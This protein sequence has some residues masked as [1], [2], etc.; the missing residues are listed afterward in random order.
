M[1]SVS[2]PPRVLLHRAA[3]IACAAGLFSGA[4]REERPIDGG[5]GP[6]PVSIY[7]IQTPR[8]ADQAPRVGDD[9]YLRS[10]LVVAHDTHPEPEARREQ[11]ST[12]EFY[13]VDG[14]GYTG[15]LVVQEVGGGPFSGIS[16]FNPTIVPSGL[17]LEPGDL[18]DVWGQYLEFC[19]SGS[20]SSADSYCQAQDTNRLSQIGSATV[21][22]VGEASA[23]EP[24][25]IRGADLLDPQRAE[26]Y[27]GT[28]VRVT[29]RL[30]VTPCDAY[31]SR[32]RPNCCIGD[33]DRYGNL[34]TNAMDLTN[35]LYS[36]PRGT[37]CL[38]SVTGFVSWFG[39]ATEWGEYSLSPRGPDD[40]VVPADCRP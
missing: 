8:P 18:V 32:G 4:C 25:D 26:Q 3:A 1:S 10:V 33:Y 23:P 30:V 12:G 40:V 24:I 16:L 35:E 6:A 22:K 31:D 19:L 11:T 27:E 28:L 29:D 13:C 15:G 9:V 20:D 5:D 37:T 14:T 21:T 36:I 34:A 7:D 17:M 39:H 38:E 2:S